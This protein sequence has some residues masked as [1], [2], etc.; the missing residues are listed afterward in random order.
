L[1][2]EKG[3]HHRH[4]SAL[5]LGSTT[6]WWSLLAIA[7]C[8]CV[9]AVG[10]CSGQCEGVKLTVTST[11]TTTSST[12]QSPTT[13]KEWTRGGQ[14][15]SIGQHDNNET[16]PVQP[17]PEEKYSDDLA[18]NQ[19]HVNLLEG[20][21]PHAP[22]S[23]PTSDR[24]HPAAD[25]PHP[26][27]THFPHSRIGR[28]SAIHSLAGARGVRRVAEFAPS[29]LSRGDTR[30]V[31]CCVVLWCGEEDGGGVCEVSGGVSAGVAGR[32]LLLLCCVS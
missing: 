21:S 32:P 7:L 5:M 23:S 31:L 9:C 2:L 11:N 8:V 18:A 4:S 20:S 27:L 15:L 19:V 26:S 10:Y 13:G 12:N 3:C 25:T 24:A 14:R 16:R 22:S 28:L 17:N 29:V 6:V 30:T 1:A